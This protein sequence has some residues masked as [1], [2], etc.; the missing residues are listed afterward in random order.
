MF[1]RCKHR[2]EIIMNKSLSNLRN[3]VTR[4]LNSF[5]LHVKDNV[6]RNES[7]TRSDVQLSTFL[8]SVVYVTVTV[9]PLRHKMHST[10]TRT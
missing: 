4:I 3:A 10:V 2:G 6:V 8:A 5:R 7:R 9:I 1:G